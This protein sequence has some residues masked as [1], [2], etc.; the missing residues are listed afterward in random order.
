VCRAF[1]ASQLMRLMGI[2]LDEDNPR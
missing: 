2:M 1:N